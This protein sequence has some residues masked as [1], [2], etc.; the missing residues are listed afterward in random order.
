VEVENVSLSIF[1]SPR[2]NS[3]KSLLSF[4][5]KPFNTSFKSPKNPSPRPSAALHGINKLKSFEFLLL[6]LE[7]EYVFSSGF[8]K[9]DFF[10][11]S[12]IESKS[13]FLFFGNITSFVL[14]TNSLNK[15][16]LNRKIS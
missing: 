3:N 1:L 9:I 14:S 6:K 4:K 2:T 5:S 16:Y 8:T 13:S 15:K 10:C 12:E 7:T 11:K